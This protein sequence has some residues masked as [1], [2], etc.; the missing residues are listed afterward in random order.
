MVVFIFFIF[1]VVIP[2][3]LF[4][5]LLILFL[6]KQKLYNDLKFFT[7]ICLMVLLILE[8]FF[9]YIFVNFYGIFFFTDNFI[10]FFDSYCWSF[11]Q[12][13]IKIIIILFS[14]MIVLF[15]ESFSKIVDFFPYH[16]VLS[17]LDDDKNFF[18]K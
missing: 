17:K 3:I 15:F 18:F 2:S 7:L 10:F 4:F 5:F 6:C 13:S 1:N 14:I 12:S 16:P 8:L 9:Q 11:Y